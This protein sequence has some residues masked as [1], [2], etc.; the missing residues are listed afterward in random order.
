MPIFFFYS[1][2]F[3]PS[4]PMPPPLRSC[5]TSTPAA[6]TLISCLSERSPSSMPP[7]HRIATPPPL[8]LPPDSHSLH[9]ST[10]P[11]LHQHNLFSL[12]FFF[13]SSSSPSPLSPLP[14]F[15]PFLTS[16]NTTPPPP[17]LL[18]A[19][20]PPSFYYIF[21][22]YSHCRTPPHC[23]RHLFFFSLID[24]FLNFFLFLRKEERDG[25]RKDSDDDVDREVMGR[26]R[27]EV[28]VGVSFIFLVLSW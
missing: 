16:A 9:L 28:E 11:F 26:R 25:G 7:C 23:C 17:P 5:A 8:S 19:A 3:P 1:S 18:T 20:L 2:F 15:L 10:Q 4:L 27:P 21:L 13:P 22:P 6:L 12:F 14:S 24:V